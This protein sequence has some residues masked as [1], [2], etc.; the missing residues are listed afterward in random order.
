VTKSRQEWMDAGA[1][2]A[3]SEIALKLTVRGTV[4]VET[5]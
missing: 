4:E 5:F 2:E 1:L 3:T